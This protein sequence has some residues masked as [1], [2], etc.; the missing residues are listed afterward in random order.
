VSEVK[1]AGRPKGYAAWRPHRKTRTILEQVDSVLDDYQEHLPLTI[2]QVFYRLV[3]IYNYPKTEADYKRLCEY[4]V[5]AR[6]AGMIPFDSLRDDGLS[7][8]AHRHYDGAEDFHR[9]IRLMGERF[10]QDKLANQDVD[11]RVYCEAEGMMPQLSRI[12][13]PY[14]VP[15]RSCSGFDSLSA[16]RDL[17]EW[18]LEV[19]VYEGKTPVVLHLGDCDPS[20]DSIF[21]SIRDDVLAFMDYDDPD[22]ARKVRNRETFRRVALTADQ[23]ERY[24]LPTAPPKG[25]DSR[26]ASWEGDTCQ[27][28]ALEPEDLRAILEV[29][30]AEWLDPEKLRRDREQEITTRR[31]LMRALPAGKE[32]A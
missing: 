6:R 5:R 4:L 23:I 11:I 17:L 29:E 9:Q 19:E 24:D 27:L 31:E 22:L 18:A 7:V 13:E 21:E 8:M 26:S 14:S 25:S 28:E 1:S 20:G 3:G 32:S 2:R 30:V 16:K 10:K 12:L 15:V